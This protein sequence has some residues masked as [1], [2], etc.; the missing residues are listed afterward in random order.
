LVDVKTGKTIQKLKTKNTGKYAITLPNEKKDVKLIAIMEGYPSETQEVEVEKTGFDHSYTVNF[1]L[2]RDAPDFTHVKMPAPTYSD[3]VVVEQKYMPRCLDYPVVPLA[4]TTASPLEYGLRELE[5]NRQKLNPIED[6]HSFEGY[7]ANH[8]ILLLDASGSMASGDRMP[9]LKKTLM[10]LANY[11]RPE[12]RITILT[13][14]G[15]V[16]V[17]AENIPA[18]KID[19]IESAL[20]RIGTGGGTH[21]KEGLKKALDIAEEYH[22]EGGNNRIILATDGAFDVDDLYA[23]ANKAEKKGIF[24]SVFGFGKPGLKKEE[25]LRNLALRGNGN[26]TTITPT[27]AEEMLIRE[28]KAIRK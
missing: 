9:L 23:L 25:E 11:M 14:S 1:E 10:E 6:P 5:V 27:N 7:A 28:A 15:N 19:V 20:K 2:T 4:N 3:P 12:D 13:Y 18:N 24:V 17:A 21:A 26:Y 16:G 22:I 8:L